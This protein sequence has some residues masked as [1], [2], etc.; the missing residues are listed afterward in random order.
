MNKKISIQTLK[1]PQSPTLSNNKENS[2][3]QRP[4]DRRSFQT[5]IFHWRME[6]SLF[7]RLF[8]FIGFKM[9]M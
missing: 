2:L 8:S 4:K 1:K 5:Q 7:D 9:F 6:S 3:R